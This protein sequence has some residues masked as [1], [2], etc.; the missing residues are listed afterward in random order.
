MARSSDLAAIL[1]G[2]ALARRDRCD[3][4][5]RSWLWEAPVRATGLDQVRHA[6]AARIGLTIGSVTTSDRSIR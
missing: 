4:L 3:A 5:A 6:V 1:I 2:Q